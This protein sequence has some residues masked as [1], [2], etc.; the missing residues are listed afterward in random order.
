MLEKRIVIM[1]CSLTDKALFT[2]RINR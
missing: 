1:N 2:V